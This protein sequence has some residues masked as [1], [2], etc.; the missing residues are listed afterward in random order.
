MKVIVTFATI[1]CAC[2]GFAT[3]NSWADEAQ[4]FAPG[5]RV[6][7]T[8]LLGDRLTRLDGRFEASSGETLSIAHAEAE[9][10]ALRWSAIRSL[11][12]YDGR[13]GYSGTGAMI[14]L[15][16]GR[17]AGVLA[18]T[19]AKRE[20][21][22]FEVSAGGA[23]LIGGLVTATGTGPGALVGALVRTDRWREVTLPEGSPASQP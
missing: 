1:F 23:V 19:T 7:V 8:Y 4:P 18:G 14:G 13:R 20:S 5:E 3:P 17:G 11:E 16:I 15:A 6:R 2:A 22:F 12:R 21:Q 9:P 10:C